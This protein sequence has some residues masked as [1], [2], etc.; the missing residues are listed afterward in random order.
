[1][2]YYKTVNTEALEVSEVSEAP[3]ASEGLFTRT[4]TAT[5]A[6]ATVDTLALSAR[7]RAI[8]RISSA[9]FSAAGS[10]FGS[11]SLSG[12]PNLEKASYWSISTEIDPRDA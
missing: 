10:L 3:E 4:K 11:E 9:L 12:N 1:L 6:D 5:L 2:R 8:S 7:R